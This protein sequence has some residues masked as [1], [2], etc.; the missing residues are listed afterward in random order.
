MHGVEVKFA[1]RE[2]GLIIGQKGENIK[3]N[4][5]FGVTNN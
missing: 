1:Q 2:I 5:N 4:N 3:R